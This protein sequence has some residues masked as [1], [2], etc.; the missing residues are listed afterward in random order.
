MTAREALSAARR[1]LQEAGIP[2]AALEA[3][4]LLREALN[5][6][7]ERLFTSL[8]LALTPEAVARFDAMVSRRLER[9]PLA[10]LTGRREFYG[11][12]LTITPDVLVPRPE[13][14]AVVEEVLRL[15]A[16][17]KAPVVADIGT[18][19]GAIGLAIAHAYPAAKVILT[20][21]SHAALALA[22][23][24]AVLLGLDR[25]MQFLHGDLTAP[26]TAP[27][28]VIAA[29][30]PYIPTA[31]IHC[32]QP[33]IRDYEPLGALDGGPDGLTLIRRLIL[34]A[35]AKLTPRGALVLEIGA[36]QCAAV[37]EFA[38]DTALSKLTVRRD[39]ACIDRV[40][41]LRPA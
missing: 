29:N 5:A 12:E 37:A 40:V 9:E 25:N 3:E 33:E 38:A 17:M 26:L 19:S 14:E 22:R 28:D 7:R 13:T 34:E 31:E 35:P 30:L 8:H 4:V 1:K 18:G 24:N 41:T 21:L 32:L 20:D 39:L 10:Y 16:T 11:T 36:G 27:V 6:P 23:R 15:I 2:D